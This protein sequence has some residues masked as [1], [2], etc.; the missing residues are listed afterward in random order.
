M[1]ELQWVQVARLEDIPERSPLAVFVGPWAIALYRVGDQVYATDDTCSH[2][3]A[4]LSEGWYEGFT[5]TCPAHGGQ[6]DIRTGQAVRMP[7]VSPIA[8]WPTSVRNAVVFIGVPGDAD[9]GRR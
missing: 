6:F 7:A 9:S 3:G 4:S 5:V 1:A 2:Q 8:T